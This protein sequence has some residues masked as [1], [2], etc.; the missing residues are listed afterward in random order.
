MTS[1][2]LELQSQLKRE[3]IFAWGVGEGLFFH[4]FPNFTL[5]EMHTLPSMLALTLLGQKRVKQMT[6][7]AGT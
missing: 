1:S 3:T 5:V 6:R 4:I 7:I 2:L